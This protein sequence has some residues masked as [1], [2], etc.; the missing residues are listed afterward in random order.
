[1]LVGTPQYMS[2][3][4]LIGKRDQGAAGDV[5]AMAVTLYE[6]LAGQPP[7]DGES[8]VEV[9]TK[10]IN[11]AYAPLAE[12][13]PSA[14]RALDD[15]FWT[16]LHR[17]PARRFPTM[18][19]LAEAFRRAARDA[20]EEAAGDT[21]RIS[22]DEVESVLAQVDAGEA[23]PRSD[24]LMLPRPARGAPKTDPRSPKRSTS[25]KRGASAVRRSS[26]RPPSRTRLRR[27]ARE[28]GR[29]RTCTCVRGW[30]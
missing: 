17:D 14:P 23:A 15:F 10:V 27:R 20:V 16:A 6:A 29:R 11:G 7:F 30:W 1:M 4:V 26:R 13:I 18:V 5:W 2:P 9:A 8:I 28:V 21:E 24:V 25:A 22:R 19:A 3:E 12:H